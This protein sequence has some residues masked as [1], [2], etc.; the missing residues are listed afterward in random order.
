MILFQYIYIYTSIFQRVLFKPKEWYMGT[1]YHR[2]STLWKIQVYIYIYIYMSVCDVCV[3]G[4]AK[5]KLVMTSPAE[6]GPVATLSS[7][8]QPDRIHPQKRTNVAY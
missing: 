3:F 8:C 1:P 6:N 5:K 4:H 2:F 7:I